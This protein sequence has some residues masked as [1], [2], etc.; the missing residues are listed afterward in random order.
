MDLDLK[1]IDSQA[2]SQ[3]FAFGGVLQ[4]CQCPAFHLDS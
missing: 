1:S 2:F 4:G 3:E